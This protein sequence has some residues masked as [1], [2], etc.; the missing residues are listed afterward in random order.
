MDFYCLKCRTPTPSEGVTLET[1]GSGPQARQARRGTCTVCRTPK[2]CFMRK[3]PPKKKRGGP[4]IPIGGDLQGLLGKLPGL[5]WSK[6]AGEKHLPGYNYCGPGTRLDKRIGPG[7]VPKPGEAP[8]NRVDNACMKH[9]LSYSKSKD[10]KQRHIADVELIHDI[11]A[12]PKKSFGEWAGGVASKAGLK[13]KLLFGG[14]CAPPRKRAR[15]VTRMA[16]Q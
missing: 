16:T 8:I 10:L 7:G 2:F 14:S 3:P 15:A 6:Y 12:I 11:D 4:S 5:P 13:T 1:V 9:D